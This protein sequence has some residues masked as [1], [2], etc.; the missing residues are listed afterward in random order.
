MSR[1][2]DLLRLRAFIDTEI[3]HERERHI[4]DVADI[5]EAV[6]DLYE[7]P[8]G[9]IKSADLGGR[10]VSQARFAVCWLLREHGYSSPQIGRIVARDHSTVLRACAVI[11]GDPA[12]MA[13]L[14]QLL[15]GGTDAARA[16]AS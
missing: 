9:W 11:D 1:L 15:H 12:R 2:H 13:M 10:K 5:V 16:A 3:A 6:G 8:P 4:P 14:R 7:L